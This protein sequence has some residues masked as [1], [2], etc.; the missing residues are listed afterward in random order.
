MMELMFCLPLIIILACVFAAMAVHFRNRRREENAGFFFM[1]ERP[2]R[3]PV[4]G[5]NPPRDWPP[6]P[7]PTSRQPGEV[8]YK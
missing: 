7:P 2:E 4:I 8:W 1:L 3:D 6:P 5:I